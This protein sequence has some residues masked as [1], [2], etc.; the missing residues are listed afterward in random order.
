M[1]TDTQLTMA[2]DMMNQQLNVTPQPS[3]QPS[4]SAAATGEESSEQ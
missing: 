1:E 3:E 2:I 4:E